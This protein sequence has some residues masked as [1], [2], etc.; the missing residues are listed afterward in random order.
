MT[1]SN[2]PMYDIIFRFGWE[3]KS[4]HT[5]FMYILT[6]LSNDMRCGKILSHWFFNQSN[7]IYG[8]TPPTLDNIKTEP[9]LAN[10]FVNYFFCPQNTTHTKNKV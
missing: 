7:E 5:I 9:D 10:L 6:Y 1:E 2:I 3:T 8:G 4:V